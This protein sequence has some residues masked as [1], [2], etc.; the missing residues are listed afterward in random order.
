MPPFC[1]PRRVST[2]ACKVQCRSHGSGLSILPQIQAALGGQGAAGTQEMTLARGPKVAIGH[3]ANKTSG[4]PSFPPF[5][6]LALIDWVFEWYIPSDCEFTGHQNSPEPLR[7]TTTIILN[8]SPCGAQQGLGLK[9]CLSM[10]SFLAGRQEGIIGDQCCLQAFRPTKTFPAFWGHDGS[11]VTHSFHWNLS[12]VTPAG[13]W[14]ETR[15]HLH[16]LPSR[17]WCILW[18]LPHTTGNTERW[19]Q[20]SWDGIYPTERQGSSW[21]LTP[22]QKAAWAHVLLVSE[23]CHRETQLAFQTTGDH[24][25]CHKHAYHCTCCGINLL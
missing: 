14:A 22:Q 5:L 25:G 17:T 19:R 6:S 8:K 3:P 15:K 7:M 18:C 9:T 4:D 21:G 13:R 12:C 11:H 20:A 10:V 1:L 23:E 24:R 16:L 2:A